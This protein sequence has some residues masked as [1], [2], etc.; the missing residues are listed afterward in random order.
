MSSEPE[1]GFADATIGEVLDHVLARPCTL[2]A[3]RLLCI[4]GPAGSGKTTLAG[5]V[6]AL[7][8]ARSLTAELVHQDDL[9]QGWSGLDGVAARVSALLEPLK[10]G[11]PATYQRWDW[12]AERWAERHTVPPVDLLIVEGVLAGALDYADLI[13]TLVW[14]ETPPEL[15]LTRGL[16]RDG[17]AMRE[18]WETWMLAEQRH[19]EANHTRERA[20]LVLDGG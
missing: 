9:Y 2:G 10:V 7:A 19:F 16:E 3:G 18:H 15:R 6:L 17:E 5:G 14:V 12:V 1:S 13:T 4:D 11:A 20:D 8:R